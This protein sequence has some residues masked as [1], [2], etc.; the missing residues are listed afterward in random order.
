EG[1]GQGLDVL[2]QVRGGVLLDGAARRRAPAA[3]LVEENDA[4]EPR[5]EEAPMHGPRLAAGTA[6]KEDHREPGRVSALLDMERVAASDREMLLRKRLERRIESRVGGIHA[7]GHY[8]AA[9]S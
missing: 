1:A 8:R 4:V 3:P 2:D 9:A 5:I 7:E 6:V